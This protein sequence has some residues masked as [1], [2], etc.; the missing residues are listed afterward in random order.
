MVVFLTA[1]I[2]VTI[3]TFVQVSIE[4]DKMYKN[5]ESKSKVIGNRLASR[6]SRVSKDSGISDHSM[7]SLVAPYMADSVD[8]IELYNGSFKALF[9]RSV[10][11]HSHI[12]Q[13][14]DM[15][16]AQKVTDNQ[17]SHIIYD[18]EGEHLLGYFPVDFIKFDDGVLLHD[19][20]MLYLV[21][22]I[23][24]DYRATKSAIINNTLMSVSIIVIM[25]MVFS[26]L[27]YFLIFRR[28]D[29]LHM[30][31]KQMA[32]GD[33]DVFVHNKGRDELTEVINTFNIMAKQMNTYKYNL[34]QE[35]DKAVAERSQQSKLLIQQ[36]RLASMGEMIGNIAHQ[37]RQP[38]NALGLIIQKFQ[39]FSDRDKLSPEIIL[40]STKKAELIIKKMSTTIDDFSDFFKPDK[41][42]EQFNIREF[43][44]EV[45]E[46]MDAGLEQHNISLKV[47]IKQDCEL[48]GYK[49]EFSQVMVNLLNN[50]RDA[51]VE[52]GV[53]NPQIYMS[54]TEDDNETVFILS[55]NAGGIDDEII[56]RIFDPYY[57]TKEEGKGTGIGLYMSKMIIEENMHGFI[58]V[59]NTDLGARFTMKFP[60]QKAEN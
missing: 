17:F 28:L 35:V 37:W 7:V 16:V 55:D 36:S 9:K 3:E 25:L 19:K 51:L 34:Q 38:L 29:T 33:F 20:A 13:F 5:A 42:K 31:T 57:T 32:E 53:D 48:Y 14:I 39:I 8:Q 30:A 26:L 56:N 41:D 50:S 60:K 54:V 59:D 24:R 47:D 43:C 52:T 22:D 49:N 15:G 23:S 46:L 11:V 6:I 12:M 27:S 18:E 2:L 10:S 4:Y 58:D 45:F 21:F 1:A 40:K 44:Q